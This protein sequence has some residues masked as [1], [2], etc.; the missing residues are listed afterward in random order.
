MNEFE[1]TRQSII[2]CRNDTVV[3]IQLQIRLVSYQICTGL[4]SCELHEM[5][6]I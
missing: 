4:K 2:I 5:E 1:K 3:D 6:N